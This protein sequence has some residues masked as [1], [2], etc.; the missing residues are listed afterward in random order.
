MTR[1]PHYLLVSSLLWMAC[2]ESPRDKAVQER[3]P[4]NQEVALSEESTNRKVAQVTDQAENETTTVKEAIPATTIKKLRFFFENSGSMNGYITE[5]H[6][7]KTAISRLLSS[8]NYDN[9]DAYLINTALYKFPFSPEKITS[10]LT[11]SGIKKGDIHT[12]DLNFILKTA[13]DST[14]SRDVG[15]LVTDGIYSVE[16]NPNDILGKLNAE[17]NFTAK[18][19]ENRLKRDKNLQTVLI[20]LNSQFKGQYYPVQGKGIAIDQKRPYY[21]WL[22]GSAG[23]IASIQK[24][25][26]FSDLPGHQN[27][28]VFNTNANKKVDYYIVPGFMNKG[29]FK[30]N[31]VA[32]KRHYHVTDVVKDS[33]SKDFQF[34]VGVDLKSLPVTKD[35]LLNKSNYEVLD[36][37]DYT[38][39]EIIAV[40]DLTPNQVTKL[41]NKNVTH[42]VVLHTTKNAFGNLKIA[43]KKQLPAWVKQTHT[44][45]DADIKG[46]ETKTLGFNHL[47]SAIDRAYDKVSNTNYYITLP[48]TLDK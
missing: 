4:I 38:I 32:T 42:I 28:L 15:M 37:A 47:V 39:K 43:L 3:D 26:N 36:N 20:K 5:H 17:S 18:H 31:K 16:G 6:D 13:L 11:I 48:L 27:H 8:A 12:S 44:L 45:N 46:D 10:A 14:S 35:Y 24:E 34:V 19:F 41:A 1:T 29:S 25:L 2:G 22:F 9:F 21:I 7:F 33:R 23:S 40:K 30:Q